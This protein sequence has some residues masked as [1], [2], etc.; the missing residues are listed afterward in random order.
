MRCSKL[1]HNKFGPF[2]TPD[3]I[4]QPDDIQSM[5]FS[6]SNPGPCYLSA[7]ERIE[8]ILD[9]HLG[10]YKKRGLT[11]A[12]LMEALK[13]RGNDSF[14]TK[15]SLQDKCTKLGIP[16]S[17]QKAGSA[18]P[19]VP[20]R[21]YSSVVGSIQTLST[22]ILLKGRSLNNPTTRSPTYCPILLVAIIPSIL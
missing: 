12:E 17:V 9:M 2:H 11:K 3:S 6:E 5:Q 13:V 1:T 22:S 18:N 7:Q 8:Q 10:K 21:F 16:F 4:L 20:S 19:K 15:K 14:G